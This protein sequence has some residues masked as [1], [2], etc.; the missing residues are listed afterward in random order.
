MTLLP[1]AAADLPPHS[2]RT[3]L[4]PGT[5][6]IPKLATTPRMV[7]SDEQLEFW[8]AFGYLQLQGLLTDEIGWI[9]EEFESV[10]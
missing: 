10:R 5:V 9:T 6:P 8:R 1:L 4:C 2:P 3:V 7:L